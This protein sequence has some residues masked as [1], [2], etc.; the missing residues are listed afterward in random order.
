MSNPAGRIGLAGA[1]LTVTC[2]TVVVPA[3]AQPAPAH[4]GPKPG[5][6]VV[7]HGANAITL[8]VTPNSSQRWNTFT[9][10]ATTGGVKVRRARVRLT[11]SMVGMDM[12]TMRFAMKEIRPA[13]YR[14]VGPGLLM[15][16]IWHLHV[17]VAPR[18]GRPFVADIRDDV[19]G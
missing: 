8:R 1:I 7:R 6:V 16:G 19:F 15:S 10:T 18:R 12:G 4:V 9:V 11:F 2:A 17:D 14:Y 3:V 13:M 5:Q